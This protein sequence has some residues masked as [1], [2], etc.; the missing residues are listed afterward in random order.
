[1]VLYPKPQLPPKNNATESTTQDILI[2]P[3]FTQAPLVVEYPYT[4]NNSWWRSNLN[5]WNNWFGYLTPSTT[6]WP[7]FWRPD[8]LINVR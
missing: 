5:G 4:W 8:Q 2:Q 3:G 6:R 7:S 1:M